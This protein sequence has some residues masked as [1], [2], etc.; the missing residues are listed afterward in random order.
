M[1]IEEILR[2]VP[3]LPPAPQIACKLLELLKKE[4][5]DNDEIVKIIQYDAV[6]TG[7]LLKACN[8]VFMAGR[9]PLASLDQAVIRLGHAEVLRLVVSLSVGSGLSKELTG[10]GAEGK[11]LWHHSIT[12][13]VAAQK[14]RE[15]ITK[16]LP[17]SSVAFTSGLMHDIGKVVLSHTMM[18]EVAKIRELIEKE[19]LSLIEAEKQV[20][21][22]D[23]AELGGA[24]LK[25]WKLPEVVIEAVAFHH[26][27]GTE[28][29]KLSPVVHLANCC[30]HSVGSSYGWDSMATRFQEGALEVLGLTPDHLERAM[31][32][33]HD[34]AAKIKAFMDIV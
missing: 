30:A 14:L 26:Q 11:A 20:L 9:E 16:P 7:K 28:P 5:Q 4:T 12:T 25:L 23:H 17:E 18:P 6:L 31:I 1:N 33:V 21:G 29:G 10:Y 24:L 8:S 34:E 3:D 19:H 22:V 15:F 27:P 32:S 13:A 2:N